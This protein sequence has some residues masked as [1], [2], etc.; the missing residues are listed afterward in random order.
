M[1]VADMIPQMSA[2]DL[3]SL[4]ANA[5]RLSE[6]EG[7]QQ[8]A[9]AALLPALEQ[10]IAAREA[11]KPVKPAKLAAVRKPRAKKAAIAA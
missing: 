3:A 10:E 9:A 5:R 1:T 8:A 6:S 2:P 11:A 4:H 7:P